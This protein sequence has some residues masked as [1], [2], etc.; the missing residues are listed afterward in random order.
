MR[1]GHI[2]FRGIAEKRR[3]DHVL[4]ALDID[5]DGVDRVNPYTL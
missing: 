3:Q 5:L 4:C 2:D 1:R